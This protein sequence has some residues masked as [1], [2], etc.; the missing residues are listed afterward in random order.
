MITINL[1]LDQIPF[2]IGEAYIREQIYRKSDIAEILE[3]VD[4]EITPD[5]RGHKTRILISG[6]VP[7]WVYMSVQHHLRGVGS[8]GYT[9]VEMPEPYIV[10]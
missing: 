10:Y 1:N 6:N 4:D 7:G 5:R 9:T 2:R 3:W 8:I